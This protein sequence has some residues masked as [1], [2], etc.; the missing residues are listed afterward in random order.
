MLRAVACQS[1]PRF[2]WVINAESEP[3]LR[4]HSLCRSM[5]EAAKLC[6]MVGEV[7]TGGGHGQDMLLATAWGVLRDLLAAFSAES[8]DS[9]LTGARLCVVQPL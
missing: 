3:H 2:G 7:R 9:G 5:F 4:C 8:L 1:N 6:G